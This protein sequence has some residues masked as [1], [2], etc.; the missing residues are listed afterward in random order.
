MNKNKTT[1]TQ[2]RGFFSRHWRSTSR[3]DRREW[4][5]QNAKNSINSAEIYTHIGPF[6]WVKYI[7]QIRSSS[8]R[9]PRTDGDRFQFF[10]DQYNESVS[11][12]ASERA[13]VNKLCKFVKRNVP[14]MHRERTPSSGAAD[15]D[16]RV[17]LEIRKMLV[18]WWKMA[19]ICT[20]EKKSLQIPE[21]RQSTNCVIR[22]R[23]PLDNANIFTGTVG[24]ARL[25]KALPVSYCFD[26]MITK[27]GHCV[28]WSGEGS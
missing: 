1:Q 23:N 18:Q 15:S 16:W 22:K 9:L 3:D 11:K 20:R 12:M 27:G 17:I 10:S 6:E 25:P 28:S 13:S 8:N 19:E 2:F 26:Q 14:T 24:L 5:L 4:P 21:W 7:E